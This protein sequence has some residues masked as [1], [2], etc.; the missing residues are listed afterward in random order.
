ML[1][2]DDDYT[3]ASW[4]LINH[5]FHHHG[6]ALDYERILTNNYRRFLKFGDHILDV[7]AHLAVHTKQFAELVGST[8]RVLA[9][10]PLEYFCGIITSEMRPLPQVEVRQLALSNFIGETSFTVARGTPEESGLKKKLHFTNP[11]IADLTEVSVSVSTIDQEVSNWSRL[12][13]IKLDIEGAEL[14]CIEGGGNTISRF[15][16][17]VSFECGHAG[18]GSYGKTKSDFFAWAENHGFT[19]FDILGNQIGYPELWESIADNARTWDFYFIPLEKAQWFRESL[20]H[21]ELLNELQKSAMKQ[22]QLR[23]LQAL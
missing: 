19:I 1:E 2:N 16:P 22:A 20:S 8:G 11:E 17:I 7:G 14:D 10:E 23:K 12:D 18:Y 21:N 4:R 5:L 9:F 6:F 13:Y 3:I 15:R